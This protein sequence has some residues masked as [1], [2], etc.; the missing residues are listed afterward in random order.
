[1]QQASAG[2]IRMKGRVYYEL[3][4]AIKNASWVRRWADLDA[5]FVQT[6]CNLRDTE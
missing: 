4:H 1:M 3:L 6:R 5:Q 2:V